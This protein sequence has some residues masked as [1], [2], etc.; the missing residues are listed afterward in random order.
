LPKSPELP[1]IAKIENQ[2][3]RRSTRMNADQ[4]RIAK[5]A[6]VASIA[7]I[8]SKTFETQRNGGSGGKMSPRINTDYTDQDGLP[9]SRKGKNL[10]RIDADQERESPTRRH[11]EGRLI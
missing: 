4:E 10:R 2:V 5:I 9:K 11:G 1:K 6:S 7:E 8:E 3:Y